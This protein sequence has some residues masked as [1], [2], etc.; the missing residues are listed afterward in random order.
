MNKENANK[1]KKTKNNK[2]DK[3]VIRGP[4]HKGGWGPKKT[5]MNE[6]AF[7][8]AL[9]LRSIDR[10]WGAQLRDTAGT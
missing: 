5:S 6:R 3:A 8:S 4:R 7:L 1:S 10:A 2:E 9:G